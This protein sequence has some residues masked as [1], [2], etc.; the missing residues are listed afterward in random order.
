MRKIVKKIV[1]KTLLVIII[2]LILMSV[3]SCTDNSRA[4]IWG[5]EMV[6]NLEKGQK[7][8]DVTWKETSLWYMTKPM[9]SLDVAET[10][11]FQEDSRYAVFEG[12]VI[13]KESK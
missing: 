2:A 8:V 5:G 9:D 11:I 6:V 13:F 1:A 7:L 12:K 10:Y 3:L 4:R